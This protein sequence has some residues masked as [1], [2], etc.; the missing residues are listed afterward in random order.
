MSISRIIIAG[1]HS[2]V[3]KTSVSLAIMA[4]LK[5]AGYRV[6]AYKVGPDY[7]DPGFHS[8]LCVPRLSRN[9]DLFLLSPDYVRK[10]FCRHENHDT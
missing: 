2:G 5:K 7:I 8:V 4:G 6:Q 10:T 9:L 3:G 1:T